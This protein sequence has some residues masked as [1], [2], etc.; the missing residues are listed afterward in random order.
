LKPVSRCLAGALLFLPF[1]SACD[2]AQ[3]AQQP[4][5]AAVPDGHPLPG[6]TAAERARFD[7][8]EALF[9]RVFTHE[10]GLGPFFNENQC[11]ACHTDPVAGG[12]GEQFAVRVT[13]FEPPD[14]C[15]LL[16]SHSGENVQTR[17]SPL[18]QE[19]GILRRERPA[20]G[21]E[22]TLFSVTFLFG[23]GLAE[24]VPDEVLLAHAD[25]DDRDGN[26]IRGRVGTTADGQI[27][28][29]G[30]KAEHA[31]IE[32]FTAGAL[33]FEMGLTSPLRPEEG[34]FEGGVLPPE[35]DGVPDP[36]IDART[37]GLLADFVRF[38]AP[39]AQRIPEDPGERDQVLRG[40]ELFGRIG[41]T[42][43]HVPS[44]PTGEHPVAALSNTSAPLYS[45]FL[46][47]DM[48]EELAG[49]C[50]VGA[51]P[52][53]YRT[54]PL[55]GVGRRRRFLHDGRAFSLEEAIAAHGGEATRARAAFRALSPVIQAELIR[56]LQ[57]L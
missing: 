26:G 31:S 14:R 4:P 7:E 15:D 24:A 18:L 28:R 36:E 34:P 49:A 48:G 21:T 6:L 23:L 54:E 44:L 29:F 57:S 5:P 52:G 20:A 25:P 40:Q 22:S 56:F 33:H 43:C 55:A 41:C 39:L 53:E 47:H 10:E 8:G 11:S 32:S 9:N 12:T 35:L 16:V 27:G 50:G 1:A 46:L 17:T 19:R 37:L 30:R 3:T 38:L 51:T 13:R 45:D 2:P 42:D